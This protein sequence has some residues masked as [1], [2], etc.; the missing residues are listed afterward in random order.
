[1]MIFI[2]VFMKRW[3]DGCGSIFD[4]AEYTGEGRVLG[5]RVWEHLGVF[6]GKVDGFTHTYTQP[7][8]SI[9]LSP[10]GRGR[11]QTSDAAHDGVLG[12][13]GKGGVFQSHLHFPFI[14]FF[15]I[16]ITYW[17][18]TGEWRGKVM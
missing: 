10:P 11:R 3:N 5:E 6:E 4:E 7:T 16:S 14:V 17:S 15:W 12:K 9:Q 2:Q 8:H 13:S 1:M 18:N